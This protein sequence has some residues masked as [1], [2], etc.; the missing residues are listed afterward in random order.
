[1][2]AETLSIG[3]QSILLSPIEA[4]RSDFVHPDPFK[5][6]LTGVCSQVLESFAQVGEV[7]EGTLERMGE[8]RVALERSVGK[9]VGRVWEVAT[10]FHQSD[11]GGAETAKA[12]T[13]A[14]VIGMPI[15]I[16]LTIIAQLPETKT[17]PET[18]ATS[19]ALP[20]STFPSNYSDRPV[21][22]DV[23]AP[24]TSTP[25][26]T[27]SIPGERDVSVG[28]GQPCWDGS[29][30]KDATYCPQG[31]FLNT[32]TDEIPDGFGGCVPPCD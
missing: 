18:Y 5:S 11:M 28:E 4:P 26:P 16:G 27:A 3:P 29:G 14:M 8:F 21:F 2:I 1:M 25:I 24:P 13:W 15:C 7:F 19:T 30:F 17:I 12:I 23:D 6:T 9:V 31:W 22:I 10:L 32:V 20:T